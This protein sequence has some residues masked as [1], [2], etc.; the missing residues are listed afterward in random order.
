MADE[1]TEIVQEIGSATAEESSTVTQKPAATSQ[2]Q[3]R[4]AE[5]QQQLV[6]RFRLA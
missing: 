5:H 6:S 1:I 4:L 3:V 2:E